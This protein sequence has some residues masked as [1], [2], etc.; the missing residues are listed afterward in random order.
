MSNFSIITFLTCSQS[1]Q[2]Q[3][4]HLGNGGGGA[5]DDL[6]GVRDLSR[7]QFSLLSPDMNLSYF[8]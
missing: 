1:L 4:I 5:V 3:P 2:L 6:A 8:E 7:L